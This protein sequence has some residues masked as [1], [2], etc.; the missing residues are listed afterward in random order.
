MK[1]G[2]EQ[3]RKIAYLARLRLEESEVVQMSEQLSAILDYVEQLEGLDTTNVEP[4]AQVIPS[5]TPFRAD[6]VSSDFPHGLV[7]KNAP[8]AEQGMFRVPQV[9]E[10]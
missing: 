6:E 8:E 2:P 4:L 9:I 1:I 7:T 5:E 3:V 10:D